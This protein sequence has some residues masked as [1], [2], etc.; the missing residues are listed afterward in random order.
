M[1]TLDLSADTGLLAV[2]LAT[3]NICLGLLIAVRYSPSRLWPHRRI[4]IFAVHNWTA[5]SV[6][7]SVLAHPVILLFSKNIRWRVLDV[8]F[9]VW[10]PVQPIENTIGAISLYLIVVVLVTSYFRLRLGRQQWK[11]F[12]YLIYVATICFFI[13]GILTDPHLKGNAIDPLDGEKIFVESC[14]VVVSLTTVWAWRYRLRKDREE[15]ALR[16]GRYRAFESP[17][18]SD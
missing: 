15:R 16:I 12:H 10:S 17:N 11:L 9:P 14:L 13:H 5:Y 2:F 18:T 4:N 6:M 8:A 1:T 7:A 3:A